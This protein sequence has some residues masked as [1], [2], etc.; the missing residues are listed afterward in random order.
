MLN[1]NMEGSRV[2]SQHFQFH[3]SCVL[4]LHAQQKC[5]KTHV[6]QSFLLNINISTHFLQ[7]LFLNTK[8]QFTHVLESS[9][10]NIKHLINHVLQGPCP[11]QAG[12]YI[13][14]ICNWLKP[15]ISNKS[16]CSYAMWSLTQYI[17]IKHQG[18]IIINAS[19][20][21]KC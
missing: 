17:K 10:L 15:S 12:I 2:Y 18:N 13:Y 8:H 16:S 20:A 3:F 21:H 1:I 4:E 11:T 9:S 6:L 14:I 7:S 5:L 19:H